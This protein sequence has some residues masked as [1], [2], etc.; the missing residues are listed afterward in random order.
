MPNTP[1]GMRSAL[2]LSVAGLLL[3]AAGCGGDDTTTVTVRETVTETATS[4]VPTEPPAVVALYFLQDGKVWPEQRSIVSGPAVAT[5]TIN[6]LLEGPESQLTTAIPLETRLSGL[7]I[8]G[9]VGS[10]EL[11]PALTD[12]KALAQIA[13]TLMQFE[14]VKRVSFNGG[15]PVGARAFEAQTPAILVESPLAGEEVESGFEVTGTAN[16]F[17]ATFQYELLDAGEKVLKKDF[18]TATSGSGTRGVFSFTVPYEVSGPT[19]G[20][21]VVFEI[22]AEDGS[23]TNER[24]IPLSLR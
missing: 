6:Q 13:Y 18:V 21:L 11:E 4:S 2:V 19:E 7:T 15:A 22:S 1:A 8:N 5:T 9:G 23:R 12:R 17:E 24:S 3:A 16:T 14:T 20:R 10:I